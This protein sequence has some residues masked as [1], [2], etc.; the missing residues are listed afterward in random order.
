LGGLS[1][2]NFFL[3]CEG[4]CEKHKGQKSG[5]FVETRLNLLCNPAEKKLY[6]PIKNIP[7]EKSVDS[8]E[9]FDFPE[10]KP[11]FTERN[12]LLKSGIF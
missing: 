8:V 7:V 9:K 1:R 3:T 2:P 5:Y 4:C 6:F 12:P 10:A 11:I